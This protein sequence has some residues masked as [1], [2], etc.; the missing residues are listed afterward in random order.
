MVDLLGTHRFDHADV[1]GD[2]S[3]VGQEVGDLHAAFAVAFEVR[4]RATCFENGVLELGELLAFGEG[5]GKGFAVDAVEFRFR[6][7]GF[8]VRRTASHAEVDHAFRFWS[9]VGGLSE[10]AIPLRS[11]CV[12][13][14]ANE[15]R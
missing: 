3:D 10:N 7:E 5:F 4:E 15:L 13:I 2:R 1:V 8:D 9:E 11:G 14:A 6:V 12:A